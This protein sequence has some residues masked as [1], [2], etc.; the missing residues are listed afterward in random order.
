M[1]EREKKPTRKGS[2]K[3]QIINN[4]KEKRNHELQGNKEKTRKQNRK[5]KSKWRIKE[6]DIKK[7]KRDVYTQDSGVKCIMNGSGLMA[8]LHTPVRGRA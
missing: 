2:K 3:E 1:K 7:I 5:K 8:L 4:E 6:K